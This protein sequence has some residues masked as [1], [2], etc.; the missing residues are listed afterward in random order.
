MTFFSPCVFPLIPAYVCYLTGSIIPEI[1]PANAK[2]NVIVRSIAFV[3]GFTFIFI[4]LGASVSV[5]GDL[6]LKNINLISKIGGGLIIILGLHTAGL[7]RQKIL[8]HEKKLIPIG[9]HHKRLRAF[10]WGLVFGAVWTPCVEPILAS[11]FKYNDNILTIGRNILLLLLYAFGLSI[12][13]LLTALAIGSL[14]HYL[15]NYHKYFPAF[16]AFSGLLLIVWGIFAITDKLSV[17]SRYFI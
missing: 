5:L 12:P 3:S 2:L 13:F 11:I 9:S 7:F 14:S 15:Q 10:Y 4:I 6:F 17:L 16:S 8:Y 1:N